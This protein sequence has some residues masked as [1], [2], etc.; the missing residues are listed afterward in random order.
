MGLLPDSRGGNSST[1]HL[2][3][4]HGRWVLVDEAVTMHY[5]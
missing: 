4:C 1:W 3:R 5:D 2:K